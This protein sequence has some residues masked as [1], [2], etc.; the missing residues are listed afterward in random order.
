MTGPSVDEMPNVQRH[1]LQKHQIGGEQKRPKG[2]YKG[3][4]HV[5]KRLKESDDLHFTKGEGRTDN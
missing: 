5:T 3:D 2:D 1:L 4:G